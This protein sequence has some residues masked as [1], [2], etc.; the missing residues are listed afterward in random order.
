MDWV[1]AALSLNNIPDLHSTI[2]SIKRVLKPEGRFAFTVPHPCFEAPSASSVMVD[3]LQRRVIGDYL[4]EGFWA[5]IHPQ[6][7]R[8]AGNYH[9]TIATYM[10]AL[11]DHGL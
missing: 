6:S 7:V 8:R 3:G 5:S 11:T 10:T 4:A 2:G 9:R 1:T